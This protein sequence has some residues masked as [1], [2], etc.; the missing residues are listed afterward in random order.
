MKNKKEGRMRKRRSI[1]EKRRTSKRGKRGKKE[2]RR[3]NEKGKRKNERNMKDVCLEGGG[4]RG[5]NRGKH[6][7]ICLKKLAILTV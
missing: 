2:K 3:K 1:K 4:G 7:L 5:E 6:V